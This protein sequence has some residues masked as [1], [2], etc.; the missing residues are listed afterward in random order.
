MNFSNELMEKAKNASSAEELIEMAKE[1]GVELS[2]ADAESFFRFLKSGGPLSDEE[3]ES[4]TGGKG[5]SDPEGSADG[6]SYQL[7]YKGQAL[8][9]DQT[10]EQFCMAYNLDYSNLGWYYLYCYN[11]TLYELCDSATQEGVQQ[12]FNEK[13][14]A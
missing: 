12:L 1:L 11:K 3:L 14:G 7:Y 8:R 6:K 2:N 13:L 10:L 4:V 5:S 9:M